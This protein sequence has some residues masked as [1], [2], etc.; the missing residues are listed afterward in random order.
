MLNVVRLKGMKGF[1]KTVTEAGGASLCLPLVRFYTSRC[2]RAW[3]RAPARGCPGFCPIKRRLGRPRQHVD[4]P[5]RDADRPASSSSSYFLGDSHTWH[6]LLRNYW[7]SVDRKSQQ[8]G[9]CSSIIYILRG[10]RGHWSQ[11]Q[12]TLG[13]GGGHWS[14]HQ[15]IAG[16]TFRDKR[17]LTLRFTRLDN[18]PNNSTPLL[19]LFWTLGGEW[20]T[21]RKPAQTRSTWKLCVCVLYCFK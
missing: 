7:D 11:S 10:S 16:V 5:A 13:R 20:S 9:I 1:L 3:W 14:G 6:P 19:L 15:W 2:T 17:P 8:H 12:L 21:K 4:Q 18:F